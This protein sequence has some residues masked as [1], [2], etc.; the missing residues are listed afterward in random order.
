MVMICVS[1]C[2]VAVVGTAAIIMGCGSSSQ[3]VP[4]P[5]ADEAAPQPET[6]PSIFDEVM[7]DEAGACHFETKNADTSGIGDPPQLHAEE[8]SSGGVEVGREPPPTMTSHDGPGERVDQTVNTAPGDGVNDCGHEAGC[9]H[10]EPATSVGLSGGPPS[11]CEPPMVTGRDD[12]AEHAVITAP[13][14]E[15][16]NDETDTCANCDVYEGEWADGRYHG[17][18]ELRRADGS[19]YIGEFRD[20]LRH[21]CG[22]RTCARDTYVG[23][24]RD[25]LKHGHGVLSDSAHGV[26]YTGEWQSG[27]RHGRGVAKHFTRKS[28]LPSEYDGEYVNDKR[29][30]V[31]TYLFPEG[32]KYVGEWVAGHRHGRGKVEWPNGVAYDGD[33]AAGQQH[34][35]GVH[36]FENGD[37][38]EGEFR[39][40]DAHGHG[41][42]R[43]ANGDHFE[44]Q[45]A[46]KKE[47]G[48][49]TLTLANGEVYRGEWL[50]GK[51]DGQF[52][53]TCSDGAN[54]SILEYSDGA[55]IDERPAALVPDGKS[56]TTNNCSCEACGCAASNRHYQHRS[57][58]VPCY[59][60]TGGLPDSDGV[61]II[62]IKDIDVIQSVQDLMSRCTHDAP[63]P[64]N[65][66][67]AVTT[68]FRVCRVRRVENE[69]LWRLYQM[70]KRHA[71]RP[72]ADRT[73]VRTS[74]SPFVEGLR[75]DAAANEVLLFHGTRF[76]VWPNVAKDGFDVSISRLEGLFGGGLYFADSATKSDQYTYPASN[77]QRR[78]MVL[79]RVALGSVYNASE[80]RQQAR[81]APDGFNSVLGKAATYFPEYVIYDG[82]LAYPEFIVEYERH[83]AG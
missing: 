30:G 37:I 41:R 17:H 75:L 7:N 54:S 35:H 65:P 48:A 73:A 2:Q 55:L 76:K 15:G 57:A 25:D 46:A 79:T 20:G 66:R 71:L 64:G 53:R 19:V 80:Q 3:D 47:H 45:W 4:T 63:L 59:W 43:Y 29:H 36:T 18:G 74:G 42:R 69:P 82:W 68:F 49:G 58:S 32:G 10:F 62:T 61:H 23:E 28:R 56:A 5:Y 21:G 60:Q 50:A 78:A 24:W 22:T 39:Q 9:T 51:R 12:T 44:G 77:A 8:Q 16:K 31:G 26:T 27:K 67:S 13:V 40:D 72:A 6:N 70:R 11:M 1:S 38:Y 83:L 52:E 14:V 81:R 34:G 33:Y